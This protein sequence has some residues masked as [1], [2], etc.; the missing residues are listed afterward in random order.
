MANGDN[1]FKHPEADTMMLTA[2]AKVRTTDHTGPVVLDY[3]HRRVGP[4][5]LCLTTNQR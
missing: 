1:V 3:G 4:S 2:Y 5:S